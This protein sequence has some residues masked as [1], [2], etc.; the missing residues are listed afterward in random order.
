LYVRYQLVD[1]N[2]SDGYSLTTRQRSLCFVNDNQYLGPPS[3][4]LNPQFQRL[5]HGIFRRS[6]T[7]SRDSV[8]DNVLLFSA[9][10]MR[11]RPRSDA[12]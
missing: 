2:S 3:F 4:P 10:S 11:L 9:I 1:A 6:D 8:A 5:A 7:P 12:G